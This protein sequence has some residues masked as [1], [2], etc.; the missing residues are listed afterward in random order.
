ACPAGQKRPAGRGKCLFCSCVP[1]PALTP[2]HLSPL[3]PAHLTAIASTSHSAPL[4]RS[5]TATQDRAGLEVK[6]LAYTSL[7]AAKS[8]ISA[9]KQVVLI[10]LSKPEPAASRIAPTF[11]QLHSA[12]A[13][14]PS[15][16]SPVS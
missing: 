13:E 7:K 4:G 16:I 1:V 14:M 3:F 5:F 11:L 8:A 9:R 6:C 12:W 2:G 15:G 10:T